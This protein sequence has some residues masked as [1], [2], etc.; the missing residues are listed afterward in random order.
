[1]DK[2]QIMELVK[3]E[4]LQFRFKVWDQL[5]IRGL[6]GT[7][8]IKISA[9]ILPQ[10]G[11]DEDEVVAVCMC[12]CDIN[13]IQ[14]PFLSKQ[15]WDQIS[16]RPLPVLFEELWPMHDTRF[17]GP[18]A[19]L[20]K[21]DFLTGNKHGF[22]TFMPWANSKYV[23]RN[24]TL[25]SSDVGADVSLITVENTTFIIPLIM[26]G[27][28][29]FPYGSG[30]VDSLRHNY[31][32]LF[33]IEQENK[34]IAKSCEEKVNAQEMSS[35]ELMTS[36]GRAIHYLNG[37]ENFLDIEIL[38]SISPGPEPSWSA[39]DERHYG[40]IMSAAFARTS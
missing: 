9:S 37:L 11:L 18:Q 39:R 10:I 27:Y 13:Q 14:A 35:D 25:Y 3:A 17:V 2:K 36:W 34:T 19:K 16:S 26:A 5:R 28:D 7:N 8:F 22:V 23:R 1:M 38:R 31:G 30:Y 29:I 33:D 4:V 24:P 21:S 15:V 32:V 20:M 6:D 12:T 40:K